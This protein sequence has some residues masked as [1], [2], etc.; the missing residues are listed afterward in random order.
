MQLIKPDLNIDF[1]GK[2]NLLMIMSAVLL[3]LSLIP[4]LIKGGPN[5]GIDFSGGILVQ[6]KFNQATDAGAVKAAL[7]PLGMEDSLVQ[8]FGKMEDNEFLIRAQKPDLELAGLDQKMAAALKQTYGET[9]EVRRVETVGPKVGKDLRQQA[10]MAVFFALLLMAVY[11]SGRFEAKWVLS[12]VMAGVL[13]AAT[14]LAH[15]LLATVLALNDALVMVMLIVIALGVTMAACWILRLRYAMG[16]VVS[17]SHDVLITIGIYTMCG[18]EFNLSSVAAILTVIG[19]SLNDTIIVYD[20]I[21]ENLRK[22]LRLPF[23][24]VI[25][26][27][28][29][30]TLSRTILTSGTTILVLV[31]LFVLGGGVIEDFALALLLGVA[32]GTYSSVYVASPMLLLMPEGGGL[33]LNLPQA[34]AAKPAPKP[35]ARRAPESANEIPATLPRAAGSRQVRGRTSKTSRAKRKKH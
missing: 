33:K 34:G 2:R 32:V 23:E 17:L 30:Q 13:I 18:R 22:N 4:L 10:L 6:V 9:F 11:I 26:D 15:W 3:V 19:Y 21:R 1:M 31:C 24:K 8:R 20:R 35:A 5:Y 7:T 16:A 28:V 27:S 12:A 25:N 29:N 14:L